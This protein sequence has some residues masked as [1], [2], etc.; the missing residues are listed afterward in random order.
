MI[1]SPLNRLKVARGSQLP[2]AKLDEAAVALIR[3]LIAERDE[4]KRQAS[5]LTN[6]KLAEKFGVHVRSIDRISAGESWGHV[7]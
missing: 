4:L 6:A 7:A 5:E 3:Q 1:D 2:Q